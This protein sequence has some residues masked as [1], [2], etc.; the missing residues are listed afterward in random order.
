MKKL[1]NVDQQLTM[2]IGEARSHSTALHAQNAG[3]LRLAFHGPSIPT[4]SLPGTV[5][6]KIEIIDV[7]Q[8]VCDLQ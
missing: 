3:V 4:Q 5:R 7:T 8:V 2:L 1:K 6:S